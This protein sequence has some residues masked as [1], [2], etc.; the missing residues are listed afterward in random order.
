[1]KKIFAAIGGIVL[2]VLL[3]SSLGATRNVAFSVPAMLLAAMASAVCLGGARKDVFDPLKSVAALYVVAFAI[4]PVLLDSP[5]L[6]KYS[7]S[8]VHAGQWYLLIYFCFVLIGYKLWQSIFPIK[9]VPRM[10]KPI[11]VVNESGVL[12]FAGAMFMLGFVCY[13]YAIVKSGGIGHFLSFKG[14]RAHLLANVHG[15]FHRFSLFMASGYALYAVVTIRKRPILVGIAACMLAVLYSLFMG[16]GLAFTPIMIFTILYHYQVKR[17]KARYM[18]IG[19]IGGI[20]LLAVTAVLRNAGKDREAMLND[21]AALI[22]DF[23]S[24]A[25]DRIEHT[26]L[27]YFEFLDTF[28]LTKEYVDAGNPL[29]NGH[30]LT[31]WFEPFDRNLFGNKL[32][33]SVNA[34]N[35]VRVLKSPWYKGKAQGSWSTMPGELVLN[36]GLL[37]ASIGMLCYG[38]GTQLISR[39]LKVGSCSIITMAIHPYIYYIFVRALYCGT[40]HFTN[41]VIYV[42]PLLFSSIFLKKQSCQ[43][44]WLSPVPVA[45]VTMP[46]I[47]PSPELGKRLHN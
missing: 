45:G 38:I 2:F 41:I 21:P 11:R 27:N 43:I 13:G 10:P 47:L 5:D 34:G 37:G 18:L 6:A 46:V 4:L 20:L 3:A 1:M 23:A 7:K 44:E 39:Q 29:L 30:T 31:T 19:M 32:T 25:G 26:L 12:W 22:R 8:S 17:I 42:A 16:R 9:A 28:M 14:G 24:V 33:D 35:F 40:Y 15:I 36:F